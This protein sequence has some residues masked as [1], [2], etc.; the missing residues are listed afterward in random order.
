MTSMV[1]IVGSII[2]LVSCIGGWLVVRRP[3]PNRQMPP[4]L[5]FFLYFWLFAF[6]QLIA[7]SLVYWLVSNT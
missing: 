4:V 3:T 2:L 6:A 7:V 1:F 5:S